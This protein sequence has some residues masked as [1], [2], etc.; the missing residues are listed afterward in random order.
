MNARY[1]VSRKAFDD[2]Q[3][4]MSSRDKVAA[5][6]VIRTECGAGLKE[7]KYFVE[8]VEGLTYEDALPCV[9][10]FGVQF[11]PERDSIST[12]MGRLFELTA[13]ISEIHRKLE[14]MS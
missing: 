7:A 11:D 14:G 3:A 4:F 5:I 6:K 9:L 10:S 2:A 8:G 12:L 13:E 1:T